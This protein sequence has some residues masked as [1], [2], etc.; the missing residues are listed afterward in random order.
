METKPCWFCMRV[1]LAPSRMCCATNISFRTFGALMQ[2]P[3]L[4]SMH[5]RHIWFLMILHVPF[6]IGCT[7]D[8]AAANVGRHS[9]FTARLKAMA[10][11]IFTIHCAFQRANLVAKRNNTINRSID[12][13]TSSFV[14]LA[15]RCE[16]RAQPCQQPY[17]TS[18]NAYLHTKSVR[19]RNWKH[20]AI[21]ASPICMH[22]VWPG[23]QS[24][25]FN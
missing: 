16:W 6:G 1:L 7:T 8:G 21:Q 20:Q 22:T 19:Q 24:A 15:S 2:Q 4:F 11:Q 14:A 9:G 13:R 3:R 18:T 10:L 23:Y 5:F 25:I 12:F 17:V